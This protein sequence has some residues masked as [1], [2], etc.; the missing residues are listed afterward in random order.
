[1]AAHR[2]VNVYALP[3]KRLITHPPPRRPAKRAFHTRRSGAFAS[4]VLE[5]LATAE[6]G[7]AGVVGDE[8]AHP[9]AVGAGVV[10]QR[11][12]DGLAD[13]ELAVVDIR[14]DDAGQERQVGV[15]L[16]L[17]LADDRAAAHPEVGVDGPGAH[18]GGRSGVGAHHE[19]DGMG[20]LIDEVPPLARAQEVLVEGEGFHA[21]GVRGR[22]LGADDG[23]GG[24]ALLAVGGAVPELAQ[25]GLPCG[26]L[27]PEIRI[28]GGDALGD[29]AGL[30]H[31]D[32]VHRHR[33]FEVGALLLGAGR[34]ACGGQGLAEVMDECA[35]ARLARSQSLLRAH[36][37]RAH[38]P[39]RFLSL[40]CLSHSASVPDPAQPGSALLP[41]RVSRRAGPSPPPLGAR[42]ERGGN[43]G[44]QLAHIVGALA[45]QLRRE[46]PM[47]LGPGVRAGGTG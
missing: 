26:G 35:G 29:L 36:A 17:E 27:S 32:P 40:H 8:D 37:V 30:G 7:Q 22:V 4:Q 34:I 47:L 23:Q 5:G 31:A 19:A 13:E 21:G 6:R 43:R 25:R 44:E 38:G 45:Q 24:V 42:G 28:A 3:L 14:L 9:V 10:A 41:H 39:H 20:G 18:A 46:E 1:M 12:A 16:V 33:R 11:P 15:R 2:G